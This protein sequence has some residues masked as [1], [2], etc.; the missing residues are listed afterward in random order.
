MSDVDL[1]A[2][3]PTC[4]ARV[5]NLDTNTT[6]TTS[7]LATVAASIQLEVSRA[8]VLWPIDATFGAIT[9]AVKT[10]DGWHLSVSV[11]HPGSAEHV[12]TMLLV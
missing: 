8:A 12:A 5:M 7:R 2:V 9:L 11:P 4:N 6:P 3:R 10:R 1:V